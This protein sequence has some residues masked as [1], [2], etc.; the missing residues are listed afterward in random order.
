[1]PRHVELHVGLHGIAG[2]QNNQKK[3]VWNEQLGDEARPHYCAAF[4]PK[5]IT[6]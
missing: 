4:V 6:V 1:M 2:W 3:D 5:Y